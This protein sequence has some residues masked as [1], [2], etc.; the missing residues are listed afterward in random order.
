MNTN[1]LDKALRH[2]HQSPSTIGKT[3]KKKK[4]IS[5]KAFKTMMIKELMEC[6]RYNKVV[7]PVEN[8]GYCIHYSECRPT[9]DK[10]IYN[11]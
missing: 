2:I 7:H 9:I 3:H 4:I 8:C 5:K 10:I 1:D 11:I 6:H